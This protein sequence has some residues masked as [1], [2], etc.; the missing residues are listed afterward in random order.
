MRSSW[1]SWFDQALSLFL[2]TH[3]GDPSRV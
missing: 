1:A 3:G 2:E